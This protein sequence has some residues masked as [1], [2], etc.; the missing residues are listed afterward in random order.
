ML[1][2]S[3]RA[4][5][6]PGVAPERRALEYFLAREAARSLELLQPRVLPT[7]QAYKSGVRRADVLLEATIAAEALE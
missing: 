2:E 6:F 7:E 5:E 4:Y 1:P 3:L